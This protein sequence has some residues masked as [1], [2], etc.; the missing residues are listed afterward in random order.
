MAE[1]CRTRH[2]LRPLLLAVVELFWEGHPGT[3]RSYDMGPPI[4]YMA[5]V[6]LGNGWL[7]CG[8]VGLDA[9]QLFE[10]FAAWEAMVDLGLGVV[11][12]VH[13]FNNGVS[14]YSNDVCNVSRF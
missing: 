8:Q 4:A 14:L 7:D 3:N 2:S 9:G 5:K 12:G 13:I 10:I 1:M 6:C 11:E